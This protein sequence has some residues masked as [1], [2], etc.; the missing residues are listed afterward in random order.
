M[1][2]HA[3]Q[4]VYVLNRTQ[5]RKKKITNEPTNVSKQAH[6]QTM[7]TIL[8]MATKSMSKVYSV[9]TKQ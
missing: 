9:N 2:A 8:L 7:S 3:I 1:T 5:K 4:H 6:K